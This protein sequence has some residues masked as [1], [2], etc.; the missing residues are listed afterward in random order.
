MI[1]PCT[2]SIPLMF[3]IGSFCT[4][5]RNHLVQWSTSVHCCST[6]ESL[7]LNHGCILRSELVL[8]STLPQYGTLLVGCT[9]GWNLSY[10]HTQEMRMDLQLQL[11]TN[12]VYSMATAC[13]PFWSAGDYITAINTVNIVI[14]NHIR[15]FPS[16]RV[17][18]RSTTDQ[19]RWCTSPV[20]GE[21]LTIMGIPY[22]TNS[23]MQPQSHNDNI[24]QCDYAL[25][26]GIVPI[27][28]I[29]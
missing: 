19:Q 18:I 3:L 17:T 23:Y 14:I 10:P 11:I 5:D 12:D 24:K 26:P 16:H 4:V 8:L 15:V 21:Y 22:I 20:K 28:N 9:G 2:L 1:R 6:S 7:H 29:V 13:Q 27:V 25:V